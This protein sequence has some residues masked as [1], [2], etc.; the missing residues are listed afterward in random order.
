MKPGK[1]ILACRSQ[2]RGDEAVKGREIT[3]VLV[4]S[5]HDVSLVIKAATGCQTVECWMVDL[6]DFKSI[7]AF[8]DRFEKEGGDR[9]DVLLSNAGITMMNFKSTVDGWE[10]TCVFSYIIIPSSTHQRVQPSRTS[11]V[12]SYVSD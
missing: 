2:S 1:L 8:A 4:S 9:L 12:S 7:S 3:I 6:A 11:I 5:S 10:S